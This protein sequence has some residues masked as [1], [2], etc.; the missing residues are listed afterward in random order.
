MAEL[1]LML[2]SQE[3]LDW[4][5]LFGITEK[6]EQLGF[7][8]LFLSDHLTSVKGNKQLNSIPIWLSLIHI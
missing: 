7:E 6:V 2:E 5:T 8:S 1:G 4:E 3:D